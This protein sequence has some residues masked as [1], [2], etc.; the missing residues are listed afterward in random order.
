MPIPHD[1]IFPAVVV[2]I[3]KGCSPPKERDGRLANADLKRDIRKILVA[4]VAVKCVLIV[5]EVRN[6]EIDSAII[7]EIA[8]G[9]SHARLLPSVLV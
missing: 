1:Q 5:R 8:D 2:K 9:E 6:M 4:V 7:V 3:D